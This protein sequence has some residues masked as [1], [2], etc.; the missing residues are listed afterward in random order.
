MKYFWQKKL[1]L[2]AAASLFGFGLAGCA[3]TPSPTIATTDSV[4]VKAEKPVV[5]STL[6]GTQS[7]Y[8]R[9]EQSDDE[10][11]KIPPVTI[12]IPEQFERTVVS[13]PTNEIPGT[14]IVEPANHYLYLVTGDGQAIR[15]G[16]GVGA[17]GLGFQ[18]EAKVQFKRK[19]PRWIPT[20][21][22]VQRKPQQYKR[23]ADGVPG[24]LSNPLGARALYLFQGNVDTYYRIHGTTQPSSIGKNVSAGCIRML[25]KDVVDL[26]ERV[27][28]GSKVIV[29]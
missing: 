5:T 27:Q 26:F 2:L 6:L 14:I 10:P 29:R 24:G 3:T 22:M 12:K 21:D 4:K 18:G 23:F 9:Y 25:N 19:W 11:F 15:Y 17:A 28:V 8:D 20:A 13:Y 7:I 16:V 1:R